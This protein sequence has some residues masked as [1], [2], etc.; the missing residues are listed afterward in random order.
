[1]TVQSAG[2]LLVENSLAELSSRALVNIGGAQLAPRGNRLTQTFMSGVAAR[3]GTLS[4][5]TPVTFLTIAPIESTCYAV[6]LGFG[7]PY[8]LSMAIASASVYPSDSYSNAGGTDAAG[9]RT[10]I[11]PT[12]GA[13]GCKVYFDNGGGDVDALNTSGVQRALTLPANQSNPTNA[14]TAFTIGWSDWAPCTSIARADG[15]VQPLLFIYTTV[16]SSDFTSG[17]T[18]APLFNTT[19]AANRGRKQYVLKAW[20][21]N[22]DF[23]DNPTG[24]DWAWEG[25]PPFGPLFCLQYLTLNPGV[26]IVGTGDSLS[27]APTNDSISYAAWRAAMDFSTPSLPIAYASMAWGGV[28]SSVYDVLLANNVAALRPGILLHQPISRNDTFTAAGVQTLLAKSLALASQYRQQFGAS[29]I[30]NIP[31]CAPSADGDATQIAAFNDMRLRLQSVAG[32][33]GIPLI[34]GPSVIGQ[35]AAP[36]DYVAGASDDNLHPNYTGVEMMV[37]PL[38]QPPFRSVIGL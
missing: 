35:S 36:W 4:G 12:G 30:W 24:T 21:N 23:A 20:T 27:T 15:G 31:G 10:T 6:R 8:N 28:T 19:P 26:Q 34:D 9:A 2:A 37:R 11:N 32:A 1:M 7:N 38:V 25:T 5:A 29:T 14:A 33:S 18:N 22:I 13:A 17:A 3:V 16:N